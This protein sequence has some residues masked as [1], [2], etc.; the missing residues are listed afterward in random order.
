MILRSTVQVEVF[1]IPFDLKAECHSP[2]TS[3]AQ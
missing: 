1:D 3:G 2:G